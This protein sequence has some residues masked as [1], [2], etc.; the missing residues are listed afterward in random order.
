MH[1]FQAYEGVSKE[2]DVTFQKF[3]SLTDEG[4][5]TETLTTHSGFQSLYITNY[6]FRP[7]LAPTD[8]LIKINFQIS[9]EEIIFK[10][11][12][13][14]FVN[15]V[16]NIGGIIQITVSFFAIMYYMYN[17]YV[18]KRDLIIY[19]I[20]NTVT[21]QNP[22]EARLKSVQRPES[23][24][25]ILHGSKGN[26]S[27]RI[28]IDH[29]SAI[30]MGKGKM[31]KRFS[32]QVH[33]SRPPPQLAK[34]TF[35]R[36]N[37]KSKYDTF[38][39]YFLMSQLRGGGSYSL[40]KIADQQ[41]LLDYKRLIYWEDCSK[42]L[43][44]ITEVNNLLLQ[45]NELTIL[46]NILLRDYH[47]K[48]APRMAEIIKREGRGADYTGVDSDVGYHR[49][50]AERDSIINEG[51]KTNIDET[52]L[53]MDRRLIQLF[54]KHKE[55]YLEGSIE[56]EED[57]ELSVEPKQISSKK[58]LAEVSQPST[59]IKL[60]EKSP[61]LPNNT[62]FLLATNISRLTNFRRQSRV[63]VKPNGNF[64]KSIVEIGLENINQKRLQTSSINLSRREKEVV[65]TQ[66][67][68]LLSAK[69]D[70]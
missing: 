2:I 62:A 32:Q 57:N 38:W 36:Q 54:Q 52:L 43:S 66:Q 21:E 46:K 44:Y 29:S 22:L 69:H 68:I 12:Y 51:V 16:S 20:M 47:C 48:L 37:T 65:E 10:R 56:S 49:V 23:L 24:R 45:L 15:F 50:K 7:Q 53:C 42:A 58:D 13:G 14:K 27:R 19:G 39:K 4:K 17:R 55:R 26:L 3:T 67:D 35:V 1:R 25:T 6:D 8:P 59:R 61:E 11:S 63:K 34:M 64:K 60:K 40:E 33:P 30:C 28:H 18:H 41:A 70:K 5:F 31:F 9:T